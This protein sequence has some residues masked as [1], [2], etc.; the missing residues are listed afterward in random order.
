[1]NVYIW[2]QDNPRWDSHIITLEAEY[3]NYW[4]GS[5]DNAFWI[6]PNLNDNNTMTRISNTSFWPWYANVRIVRPWYSEIALSNKSTTWAWNKVKM[7]IDMDTGNVQQLHY[8]SSWTLTANY[9]STQTTAQSNF[10]VSLWWN[11]SYYPKARFRNFKYY[12]GDYLYFQD[13]FNGTSL[14]TDAWYVLNY[15]SWATWPV[16]ANWYIEFNRNKVKMLIEKDI[17]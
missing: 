6:N 8:N 3:Y 4:S 11:D 16:V 9:S 12:R 10:Y 14:N 17:A 1:M 5:Y 2:T 13:A 7:I 15:D